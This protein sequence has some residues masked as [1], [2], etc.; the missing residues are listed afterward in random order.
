M[1]IIVFGEKYKLTKF[2]EEKLQN[3]SIEYISFSK[4]SD[5]KELQTFFTK[6]FKQNIVD[7][8]VLNSDIPLQTI[9]D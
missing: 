3:D 8:I 5:I 2:D 9:Y 7:L 4:D 1:H 6:L